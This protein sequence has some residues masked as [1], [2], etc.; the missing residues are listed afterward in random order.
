MNE[1]DQQE[2]KREF[3]KEK[4]K[5]KPTTV[6]W[7]VVSALILIVV[8][9]VAYYR[10]FSA[11]EGGFEIPFVS[12]RKSNKVANPLDGTEVDPEA[13]K[14][15]PLAIM[16]EN[17]SAARPQSGLGQASI[18]Y[19]A[20]TEGGIT[21]FMAVFGPNGAS[22]VG[23]V[24]SARTYYIDWLSEFDAFYVH[25]GGNMDA[26][27][28]IKADGVLDL[29]QFGLGDLAYWREP[30]AGK[31]IEHTMYASTDKL[32]TQ[33]KKKGW[34][35]TAN[36]QAL[37]FKNEDKEASASLSQNITIDFSSPSYKVDWAFDPENNSYLRTQAGIKHL[38]KTTGDQLEAK[39]III[40]E[41]ERWQVT[42]S[43]NEEG[44]AM[45]TIGSGKAKV[46]MEGQMIEATWTKSNRDSRTLF[47]NT[48]GKEIE[49]IP[50]AFWIEITPPDVFDKVKIN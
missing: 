44:W 35:Q 50:G 29:D 4:R 9:G 31:A 33:A 19:E 27:D 10:Y 36:F 42:T 32:Y 26:L 21:R 13:A 28:K 46:F 7:I 2:E 3:G 17:H 43:I 30:E 15:Y 18:V 47:H 39:N 37:E 38:D 24:R 1:M 40:Q 34:P 25:V 23:P 16:V 6:I 48:N 20:I 14:R 8:G 11:S 41:I 22:K 12:E 49:F 5:I 45:R